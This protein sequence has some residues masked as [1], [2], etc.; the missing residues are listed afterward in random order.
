[1]KKIRRVFCAG[2]VFAAAAALCGAMFI[3]ENAG[4]TG[5]VLKELKFEQQPGDPKLIGAPPVFK[6]TKDTLDY[7]QKLQKDGKTVAVQNDGSIKIK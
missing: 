2:C 5:G 6:I 1:M 7:L 3:T 4:L